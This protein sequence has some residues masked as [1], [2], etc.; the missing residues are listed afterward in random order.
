MKIPL[1][2]N[3]NL[4]LTES[5]NKSQRHILIKKK[6]KLFWSSRAILA[7]LSLSSFIESHNS[8]CTG[9]VP[10]RSVT[11]VQ[12]CTR[13]ATKQV[14]HFRKAIHMQLVKWCKCEIMV[15]VFW[16]HNIVLHKEL[17]TD[18]FYQLIISS[19]NHNLCE[20]EYICFTATS[21]HSSW[22]LQWIGCKGNFFGVLQKCIV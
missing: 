6:K 22:K 9:L 2:L 1:T 19:C 18:M 10:E 4:N 3:S 12:C 14:Y 5:V 16:G 21:V 8:C 13:C 20:K 15:K 17:H 7:C 11:Q